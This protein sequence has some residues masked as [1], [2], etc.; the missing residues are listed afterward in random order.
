MVTEASAFQKPGTF[1]VSLLVYDDNAKRKKNQ[2]HGRR[3]SAA[4]GKGGIRCW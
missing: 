1:F 2:M 3:E 4:A